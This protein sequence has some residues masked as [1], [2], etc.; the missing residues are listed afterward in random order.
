MLEIFRSHHPLRHAKSFK[1]AFEGIFHA[2][3][4]E[5][6]FRVQVVIVALA[7]YF[8]KRF[9]ITNVEWGLLVIS[10][11]LLLAAEIINTVVEEVIDHFI[12]EEELVVKIL[13]DLAAGFVLITAVV[14]LII[15]YLIFGKRF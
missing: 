14:T 11:G 8:G 9:E 10:L 12:K 4:N 5:P 15:L 7:V 3:L 2:L 1:H 6:N 13:K